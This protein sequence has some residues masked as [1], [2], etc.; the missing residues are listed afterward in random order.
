MVELSRKALKMQFASVY[1]QTQQLPKFKCT[2]LP[3]CKVEF[4]DTQITGTA[5]KL[6]RSVGKI[7]PSKH[8]IG[9]D[10]PK[11]AGLKS[12]VMHGGIVINTMGLGRPFCHCCLSTIWRY[13]I[14]QH[15]ISP[16]WYLHLMES[17]SINGSR[18]FIKTSRTWQ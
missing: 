18:P 2:A 5:F 4:L 10:D 1:G 13:T 7:P 15:S 3:T 12:L 16:R 14:S 8:G 6:Q 17:S 9:H 11:R